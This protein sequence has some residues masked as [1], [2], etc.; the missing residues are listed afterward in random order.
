MLRVQARRHAA[1]VR[2]TGEVFGALTERKGQLRE[3][4]AN[5]NRVW[6]AIASRDQQLADTFRV[7]PDLPAREP[8][9]HDQRA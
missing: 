8:R 1:L 9:D 6:S 4:I 5:S 2:D 7:L 3:L